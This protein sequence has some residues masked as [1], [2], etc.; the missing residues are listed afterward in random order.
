MAPRSKWLIYK[1]I[2]AIIIAC[3][4]MF[5][6]TPSP[7]DTFA[8]D[9]TAKYTSVK[10]EA[11]Q[12]VS[13]RPHFTVKFLKQKLQGSLFMDQL[14]NLQQTYAAPLVTF[15]FVIQTLLKWTLLMPIRYGSI[16]VGSSPFGTH[17]IPERGKAEHETYKT[18]CRNDSEN[19]KR[20][21]NI[22]HLHRVRGG[23]FAGRQILLGLTCK[24]SPCFWGRIHS[25]SRR[26]YHQSKKES[27]PWKNHFIS[28]LAGRT[29]SSIRTH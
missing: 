24:S 28:S 16:F 13:Y 8:S 20:F 5:P 7:A 9:A 1:W 17:Y 4:C 26:A 2:L 21:E 15:L 14:R 3:L 10:S 23:R 25:L 6:A 22:C 27:V 12:I 29:L 18:R 11:V 19:R